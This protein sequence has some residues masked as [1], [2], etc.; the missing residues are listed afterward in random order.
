MDKR[1]YKKASL[2][3]LFV[4]SCSCNEEKKDKINN[5]PLLDK[6]Q[7]TKLESKF[8]LYKDLS[9]DNLDEKGWV[10]D[11]RCDGLIFQS[12]Y[13]VAVGDD[14]SPLLAEDETI[15]GKFFRHWKKTCYQT[16]LDKKAGLETEPG[17]SSGSENSSDGYIGL[18]RW[19]QHFDRKDVLEDIINWG[20]QNSNG[21][22][23][24][25][26]EG[27]NLGTALRPDLIG[28]IRQMQFVML[29][30]DKFNRKNPLDFS[31]CKDFEC[32]LRMQVIKLKQKAKSYGAREQKELKR[33]AEKYTNNALFN[34]Y[35]ACLEKD[36]AAGQRAYQVLMNEQWFPNDRLPKSTDRCGYYLFEREPTSDAWLPCKSSGKDKNDRQWSGI[37][38]L[39]AA[40]ELLDCRID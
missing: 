38:F 35:Y 40:K 24:V 15:K 16:F 9:K 1:A 11:T 4:L 19:V 21:V 28:V 13:A 34:G 26:G 31:S 18:L 17:T 25:M 29:G 14:A 5:L 10:L 39:T 22:L 36:R 7:I 23:W 3:I 30:E 37:D 8:E 32:H 12:L 27:Q 33:L 20:E 2:I 6:P